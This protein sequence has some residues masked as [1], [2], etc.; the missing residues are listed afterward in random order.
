MTS[1]CE[2]DEEV[3]GQVVAVL[4]SVRIDGAVGDQVVAV[5]GSVELGPKA[6]VRGD[7]ISVGGRVH[8]SEGARC[9]AA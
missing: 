9:A 6:V 4:G 1:G 2:E 5:L 7:I 3:T 8:R